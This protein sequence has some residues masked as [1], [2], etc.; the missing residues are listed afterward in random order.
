MLLKGVFAGPVVGLRFQTP[1]SSGLTNERGEFSYREGERIAFLVGEIPVGYAMGAERI[2]MANLISRVDGNIQK[3]LD[4]GLTNVARFLC[5]LDRDGNLDGG[6]DIPPEVHDLVGLRSINF[7]WDVSFA[8][9]H[10]DHVGDFEKDNVVLGVFEDLDRVGVFTGATPRRLCSAATARNEVRRNIQG[11]RRFRDVKIPTQDGSYVLGDVFRPDKDGDFPVIMSCGVYGRAFHHHTV[12]NDADFERHEEDEERYFQGNSDGLIFENHESVNT[13]DWVPHDYVV[14]RLDGPGTGKNPG[15]LAV[16]GYST[17]QAYRDAIDW[18]G[19]QAWC[20]GNVGLWGL[21]YLAMTQHQVASLKPAHLKAMIAIGTDVD[22]YEEVVYTGGILNEEFFPF[23]FKTGAAP[24]N[25]GQPD[26]VDF[27]SIVRNAPFKDSD[28]SAIFG[29]KSEVFM[30]PDMSGVDVPLWAVAVTTHPS[31]LHQLGSS[32]AYFAT[33]TPHKKIDFWEDWFTKSY[34]AKSVAEH[35]AF[36][37]HWLKGVDNGIMATPPVRLE[38]RTGYGSSYIQEEH[39]WPVARTQYE[40][41]YLDASPSDWKG[42]GWRADFNRLSQSE[43]TL[44]LQVEYSADV[45]AEIR[46]GPPALLRPV[47]VGITG[48]HWRTGIS[49]VSDPMVEDMVL[50]GYSKAK[51]W[52]SSTSSDMDLFLSLRV[53]DERDR[54]VDYVGP[55]TMGFPTKNYPLAKGWL[56]VS[57]R[58]IDPARSTDYT[59]KHT[60]LRADHAP[61]SSGE[62]VPVEVEIIPTAALIRKAHRIRLDIQPFDGIAHGARHGY[63]ETYHEGADN[64]IY[65]GPKRSSWIQLPIVPA[66]QA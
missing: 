53:F 13:A 11:I 48:L 30:S 27:M 4:P 59:V 6:I 63:D 12:C 23:W 65:T 38:I 50:A 25:C 1:S 17:A 22:M 9:V 5:S 8:G 51:L 61:L 41:W 46:T 26:L 49:F 29:P 60:H 44:E 54:E 28:P 19:E 56:K 10:A 35:R 3:L 20:N 57:H 14:V 55:V 33:R 31:H 37:D 2:T 24:A 18:A 36:F 32:E 40:R 66:R 64:T 58:K 52:V 7:R 21:S 15:K 45:P 34:S 39:E 42:D 62:V 16:W 43:P 47:D